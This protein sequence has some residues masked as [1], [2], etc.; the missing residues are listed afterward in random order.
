M[1]KES[2][3]RRQRVDSATA[4]IEAM[5]AASNLE[6]VRPPG[7]VRLQDEDWPY[8]H[9]VIEEAARVEW[10]EHQLELAALLARAMADLEREQMTLREEGAIVRGA[11]GQAAANPR[12]QIV[13]LHAATIL[14]LRRSL[15]IHSRAKAGEARDVGKRRAILKDH[16]RSSPLRGDDLLGPAR[17][18]NRRAGLGG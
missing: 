14:S 6:E 1:P 9:N 13:A 10:T 16:E 2:R 5:K 12:K 7:H 4:A 15:G 3:P 11:M 18:D 17:N 8:W